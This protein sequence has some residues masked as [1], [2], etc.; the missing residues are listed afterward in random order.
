MSSFYGIWHR[1][2]KPVS[3]ELASKMQEQF[4]WWQP[5]E[6]DY[7]CKEN[8]LIGQATLWN[9][10][11]SKHE[12][13]PLQSDTYIL[14]M[15]ARIDNREALAKELDLPSK[16]LE[17]IGDSEFILAAYRKWGEECA[18]RLLGDFAFVIWDERREHLF[19]ARDHLGIKQ[20]YYYIDKHKFIFATDLKSLI[21]SPL[22][23]KLNINEDSVASYL[24]MYNIVNKDATFFNEIKKIPYGHTLIVT[25][26]TTKLQSYWT[27]EKSKNRYAKSYSNPQDYIKTLRSLLE[28]SVYARMRS[29]YTL[30]SHLSGGIDS[31]TIAVLVARKLK[32]TNKNKLLVLNWI[33]EDMDND[34][35]IDYFE[36][37]YSK[38]IANQEYMDHKYVLINTESFVN[39]IKNQELAYG[40]TERLWYEYETRKHSQSH[41]S[42][43]ILSGWGG[44]EFV[45][46]HGKSIYID[47]L[48]NKKWKKLISELKY[49]Y[50]NSSKKAFIKNLYFDFFLHFIPNSFFCKMPKAKCISDE[51]TFATSLLQ[52]KVDYYQRLRRDLL[53]ANFNSIKEEMLSELDYNHIQSR[54]ESWYNESL[55]NKIEYRYPLLDKELIEF[56]YHTPSE[57]FIQDKRTRY[58]FKKSV[59]DL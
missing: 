31:S 30:T 40:Q 57:F 5:D 46:Y 2:G 25:K 21:E 15:D 35:D 54:I 14:A 32:K 9:T 43:T 34:H 48:V 13:L 38:T 37:A 51:F 29:S 24:A 59:E 45:T 55:I 50:L 18:D 22:N 41:N 52:D 8:L 36:W 53:S 44:D 33:Q 47:L 27:L 16:P 7:I 3:K 20:L 4:D 11:E 19:C 23:L 58:Y 49:I 12:H 17:R 6:S 42:R 26:Q 1:D 28:K 56:I 39:A 10:P